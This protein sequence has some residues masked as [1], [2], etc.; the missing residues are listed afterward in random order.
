[1]TNN[2]TRNTASSLFNFDDNAAQPTQ[3]QK[4][5]KSNDL[6]SFDNNAAPQRKQNSSNLFDRGPSQPVNKTKSP[7][8]FDFDSAPANTSRGVTSSTSSQGSKGDIFNQLRTPSPK[9]PSPKPQPK[10]DDF[11]NND[12]F[13]FK[14]DW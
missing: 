14:S 11:F 3:Q 12:N 9:S 5:N 4:V 1:M 6:F 13:D 8:L 10:N 2:T 7:N